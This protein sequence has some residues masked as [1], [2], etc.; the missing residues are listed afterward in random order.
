M[1]ILLP[2]KEEK[3]EKPETHQQIRNRQ[4]WDANMITEFVMKKKVPF[5]VKHGVAA[6]WEGTHRYI[7]QT[8]RGPLRT[9]Q[10]IKLRHPVVTKT[11][12]GFIDAFNIIAESFIDYGFLTNISFSL[13]S[14]GQARNKIH[15]RETDARR[16]TALFSAVFQ[17]YFK[18]EI[19]A[20][21]L[22][23]KG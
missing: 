17:R 18:K 11:R 20:Y 8:R 14:K 4:R 13:T 15:L 1:P 23:I 2:P 12:Q 6:V 19:E 16:R 10:R 7:K 22:S 21:N 9:S 5:L 3:P